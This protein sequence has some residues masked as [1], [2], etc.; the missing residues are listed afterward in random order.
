MSQSRRPECLAMS[1]ELVAYVDGELHADISARVAEHLTGCLPCRRELDEVKAADRLLTDVSRIVPSPDFT[2]RMQQRLAAAT[3]GAGGGGRAWS[4]GW[5]VALAAAAAVALGL[6]SVLDRA[7]VDAPTAIPVTVARAPVVAPA[8]AGGPARM[9]TA[10][11]GGGARTDDGQRPAAAAFDA[12][13]PEDLPPD[14]MARPEL[15][16]RLPV[17]RR[18]ETLEHFKA[19]RQRDDAD[20]V[21]AAPRAPGRTSVRG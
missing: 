6:V 15:Y 16:L 18:L 2:D 9:A 4:P 7:R 20:R 19:E 3:D 8:A 12:L 5:G 1:E 10:R 14:L 13:T 11:A 17:V 21:G